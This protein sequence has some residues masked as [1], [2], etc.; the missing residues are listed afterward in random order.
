[1]IINNNIIEY[2]IKSAGLTALYHLDLITVDEFDTYDKMDKKTR[3]V[4]LGNHVKYLNQLTGKP[5]YRAMELTFKIYIDIFKSLNNISDHNIIEVNHDAL[6]LAGRRAKFTDVSEYIKLDVV[7]NDIERLKLEFGLQL[8][9]VTKVKF[10]AKR[11]YT[12][13]V[14]YK[15]I[16]IY[17]NSMTHTLLFRGANPD[18]HHM[19]YTI[20]LDILLAY[21]YNDPKLYDKLHKYLQ[22]LEEDESCYGNNMINN[23]LNINLIRYFIKEMI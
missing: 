7:K 4:E 15:V 8:T 1:M 5:I 6:W 2:D 23:I 17:L 11:E 13:L 18:P 20:I 10:V 16:S 9:N 19:F 21:E 14:K 22:K 3:V 12:L